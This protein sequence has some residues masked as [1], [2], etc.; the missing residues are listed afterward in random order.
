M[1]KAVIFDLDGTLANTIDSIAYFANKALEH[2]G[3]ETIETSKYRYLVG[4]GAD[5]LVHKILETVGDDNE[6]AFLKVRKLYNESYDENFMYLTH[7]YEGIHDLISSL[8]AMGIKIGVLSNKPHSTTKKVVEELF[9]DDI[10]I[11][12]G[13]R[14]GIPKKPDPTALLAMLDE[15]GIKKQD[16]IYVGDTKTDMQTGHNAGIYTMGVLWGFRDRKELEENNADIIIST[17]YDILN[18]IVRSS[19]GQKFEF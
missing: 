4:N 11:C 2:Y 3:Y 8:K 17:P 19:L 5:V 7:A 18:Y 15:L 14:E 16:C 10:D 6:D 1:I 12:Y 13:K 9:S